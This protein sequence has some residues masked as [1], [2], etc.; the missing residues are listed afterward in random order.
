MT[1]AALLE[2]AR[3]IPGFHYIDLEHKFQLEL[4][5]TKLASWVVLPTQE[6]PFSLRAALIVWAITTELKSG[7]TVSFNNFD[8][9][10]LY[11]SKWL[12][13]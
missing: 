4:S 13:K 7:K 6:V 8:E 9:F 2:L 11:L 10:N 12:D 1:R 5:S 3:V